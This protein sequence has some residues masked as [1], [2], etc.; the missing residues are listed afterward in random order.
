VSI[1]A[2][3]SME[4]EHT[5]SPPRDDDDEEYCDHTHHS[6]RAPWLRAMVLGANDGLVSIAA[7]LMGVGAG[8][9]DLSVLRLSGVAGLIAG[10]LSMAVGEYVSVSS[11]RD[12]EKADIEKEVLEQL[13]GPEAQRRELDE[14]AAIYEAR[15][16]PAELARQVAVALTEKDVIRAHARDELGIDMDDLANPWQAAAVSAATFTG[17]AAVPL[18]SA[19]FI[20]DPVMRLVAVLISTTAGLLAFGVLGA[21]LGGAGVVKGGVRVLIGGWIALGISYGVGVAFN[22][23]AAR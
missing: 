1:A 4:M 9:K 15:G 12:A 23:E 17:G 2:S 8:T 22:V 20:S 13:K 14:L 6:N 21:W 18:L 11:Q 7:L 19:I 5:A 3:A 10:A 16:V